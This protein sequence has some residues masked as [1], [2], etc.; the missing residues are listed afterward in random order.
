MNKN[1]EA[2]KDF[3]KEKNIDV[4]EMEELEGDQQQTVVFR[5]RI[6]TEGQQLPTVVILD[7]SIFA[8]VGIPLQINDDKSPV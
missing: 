2:F 8:L 7:E 1:A 6:T 3:L 4:F 5:S